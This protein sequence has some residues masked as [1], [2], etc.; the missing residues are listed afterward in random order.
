MGFFVAL[1]FVALV[2]SLPLLG[3]E[4][5]LGELFWP[6][7]KGLV[8]LLYVAIFPTL[9]AQVFFIR[10][11]E[12]IG[13]GRATLFYNLTPGIGAIFS[14]VFLREPFELY[15]AVALAL[16]IGGVMMAERLGR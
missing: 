16:V 3:A 8:I 4:W 9:L 1:G 15:H 10:G 7:L 14:T 5:A 13:P 6:S 11:V 2:T 12:L